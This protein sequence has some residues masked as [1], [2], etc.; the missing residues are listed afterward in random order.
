[1]FEVDEIRPLSVLATTQYLP[2]LYED[3]DVQ[4][5]EAIGIKQ[6]RPSAFSA[7]TQ[8][9]QSTSLSEN[10]SRSVFST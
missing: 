9:L 1:M 7:G 3:T 4:D 8:T 10:Y 6:K 2:D 5:M